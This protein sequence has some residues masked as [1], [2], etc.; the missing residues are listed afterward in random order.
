MITEFAVDK[1][2]FYLHPLII[3]KNFQIIRNFHQ[4]YPNM[5]WSLETGYCQSLLQYCLLRQLSWFLSLPCFS[6]SYFLHI[7]YLSLTNVILSGLVLVRKILSISKPPSFCLAEQCFVESVNT[8]QLLPT[9]PSTSS[10]LST[11]FM[12]V[13][14]NTIPIMPH[15]HYTSTSLAYQM[16]YISAVLGG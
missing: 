9:K 4:Q 16:F 12:L 11:A 10:Y 5:E 2:I 6:V 3:V 7:F 1:D 8:L 14:L 15:S 13:L